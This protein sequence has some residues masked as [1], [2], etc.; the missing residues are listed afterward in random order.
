VSPL[1][2]RRN[3]Q[4]NLPREGSPELASSSQGQSLPIPDTEQK[5]KANPPELYY[6]GYIEVTL[7]GL[8]GGYTAVAN[9][10][11]VNSAV[12]VERS[13]GIQYNPNFL[14]VINMDGATLGYVNPRSTDVLSPLI[15]KGDIVIDEPTI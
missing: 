7:I 15:N 10:L 3:T 11:K 4:R 5:T 12:K 1:L 13:R 6:L 2:L 8:G 9:D 14:T